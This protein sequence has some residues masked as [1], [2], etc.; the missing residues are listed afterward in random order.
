MSKRF[1]YLFIFL[2]GAGS[3]VVKPTSVQ[4]SYCSHLEEKCK[5]KCKEDKEKRIEEAERKCAGQNVE[6]E[7]ITQALC[8]IDNLPVQLHECEEACA[9]ARQKCDQKHPESKMEEKC[10][11]LESEV[12]SLK[13][14]LRQLE[15]WH[16][17]LEHAHRR[18]TEKKESPETRP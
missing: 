12:Q 18:H 17:R 13:S 4:S 15:Y 2:M 8:M 9:K 11:Q 5:K 7:T 10:E 6:E 3:I 16:E 1:S 14:Q